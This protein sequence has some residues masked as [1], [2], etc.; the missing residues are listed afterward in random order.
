MSEQ[1]TEEEILW[2]VAKNCIGRLHF[3]DCVIY[4]KDEKR[5]VS[6]QKAAHGLKDPRQLEYRQAH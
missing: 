2:D 6:V 4:L 1:Q 3:E 5:N